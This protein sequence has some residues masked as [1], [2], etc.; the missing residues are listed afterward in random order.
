V[1]LYCDRARNTTHPQLVLRDWKSQGA[2]VSS[3][4]PLVVRKVSN[5][6]EIETLTSIRDALLPKLI[7]GELE[8]PRLEALGLEAASNGE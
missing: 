1:V 2:F 5:F 6:R 7:S 4:G 8:A 3:V